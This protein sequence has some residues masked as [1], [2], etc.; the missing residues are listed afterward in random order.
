LKEFDDGPEICLGEGSP[1][2]GELEEEDD[3]EELGRPLDLI[4]LDDIAFD[5]GEE[6]GFDE[7]EDEEGPEEEEEEPEGLEDEEEE[8]GLEE[9]EEDEDPRDEEDEEEEDEDFW[10]ALRRSR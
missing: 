10:S 1:A 5:E 8:E 3:D 7:D 4:S 2:F 6:E 9:D